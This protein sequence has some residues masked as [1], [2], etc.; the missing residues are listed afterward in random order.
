M[1]LTKL[2]EKSKEFDLPQESIDKGKNGR[3]SFIEIFPFKKIKDLSIDQY[4]QGTD[5]NSFCYWLE[6][7]KI[8]L[9]IGGCNASKF[10]V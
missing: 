9:G 3:L 10:K 2:N 1:S 6:F 5:K 7:K 4:V 8:H